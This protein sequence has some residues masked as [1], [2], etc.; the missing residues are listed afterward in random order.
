MPDTEPTIETKFKVSWGKKW[1]Q[2]TRTRRENG[3]VERV[4]DKIF[5][6]ALRKHIPLLGIGLGFLVFGI[7]VINKKASLADYLP[8]CIFFGVAFLLAIWH[9]LRSPNNTKD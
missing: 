5:G 9:S 4:L 7:Y 8:F 6:R 3:T 2:I 1:F